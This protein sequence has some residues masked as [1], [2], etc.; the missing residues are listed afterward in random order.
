MIA[1]EPF[2]QWWVRMTTPAPPPEPSDG[3]SVYAVCG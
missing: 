2:W 1:P 3:Q